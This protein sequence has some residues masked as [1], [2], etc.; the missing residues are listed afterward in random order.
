MSAPPAS[1]AP[2]PSVRAADL[3]QEPPDHRW[4]L[5]GL[6]GHAAVGVIGGA[7]KSCKSWLGLDIAV[8]VASATT[9]LGRFAVKEAGPAL[10][11]LAEDALPSVR[12]RIEGI[13]RHRDL[14]IAALDLHV[15]TASSL[16]L[17]LAQDRERL[18]LSLEHLR[19][20]ILLLDPLVR[21]HRLDE[22]NATEISGLLGFL[23]ELQR[24]FDLAVVLVHHVSKRNAQAGG[25]SLRGSSD[26]HAWTDSSAY[27]TRA[28]ERVSLTIEHRSAPAPPPLSFRLV[29]SAGSAHLEATDDAGALPESRPVSLA[30]NILEALRATPDPL[31]RGELRSRLRMNNQRL[32]DAL[33][34]LEKSGA[35]ERAA[36]GWLPAGAFAPHPAA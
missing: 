16:R 33:V 12:S 28:G 29:T 1:R 5:H 35:I 2:L 19:P 6:W 20:R 14:D 4:L 27:L 25:L 7:P 22:N 8:S 3:D 30:D 34:H 31:T 24:T 15:I 13:C 26:I 32:G 21:L 11:Y 9:C 36:N 23:R 18:V 10:V 17:D